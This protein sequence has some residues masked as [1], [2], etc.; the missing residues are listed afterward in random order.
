V[1]SVPVLSFAEK[2]VPKKAAEIHDGPDFRGA[3]IGR[4]CYCGAG[5]EGFDSFVLTTRVVSGVTSNKVSHF[6]KNG[7]L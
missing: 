4:L 6:K 2:K 5:L 1:P 7:R 3:A